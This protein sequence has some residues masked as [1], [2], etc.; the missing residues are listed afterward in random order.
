MGGGAGYT[1]D[2][3]FLQA[4]WTLGDRSRLRLIANLVEAARERV[5]PPDGRVLY[6]SI[7]DAEAVLRDRVLPGWTVIWTLED[8]GD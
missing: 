4:E 7:S 8:A 3:H 6:A 1:A 5:A 2:D